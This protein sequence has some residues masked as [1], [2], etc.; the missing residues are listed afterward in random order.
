MI[1]IF[2]SLKSRIPAWFV[3]VLDKLAQIFAP[4]SGRLV[5]LAL[6]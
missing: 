1:F 4:L 3:T 2:A 5:F 6:S